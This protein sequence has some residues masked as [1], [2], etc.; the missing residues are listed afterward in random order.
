MIFSLETCRNVLLDFDEKEQT[1]RVIEKSESDFEIIEIRRKFVNKPVSVN[2][3]GEAFQKQN[4]DKVD[5]N[6]TG[7][8]ETNLNAEIGGTTKPLRKIYYLSKITSDE[9]I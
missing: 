4:S 3:Q 7:S 9:N 6:T 5:S 1:M 8:S 2:E